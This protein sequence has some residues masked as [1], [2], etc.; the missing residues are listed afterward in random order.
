MQVLCRPDCQGMCPTCG[1][2]RNDETCACVDDDID[3]RFAALKKLLDSG[4]L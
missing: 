1:I 4:D 2:N 3:P